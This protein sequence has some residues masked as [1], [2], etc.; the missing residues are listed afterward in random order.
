MITTLLFD[1][2]R[3]LLFPKDQDYQGELNVLHQQLFRE[4]DYSF[5]DHF[6]L[7]EPLLTYLESVKDKVELYIFTSGSIQNAPEIKSRIDN[8][9][10]QVISAKEIGRSKKDPQAY[11]LVA[12]KIGKSPDEI[13]FIDDSA[14][15][16]AAAREANLNT[17]LYQDIETLLAAIQKT[18]ST[19]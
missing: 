13:L 7:N 6:R 14:E 19:P 5:L 12:D 15:N 4:V 9:F 17:F 8:V 18:I 2:S 1:F 3:V 11:S 16:I 10:R